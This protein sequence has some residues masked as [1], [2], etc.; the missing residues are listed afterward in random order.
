[1]PFDY[2]TPSFIERTD[3]NANANEIPNKPRVKS[4]G[5]SKINADLERIFEKDEDVAKIMNKHKV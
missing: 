1:M 5:G 4:L 2:F 3:H